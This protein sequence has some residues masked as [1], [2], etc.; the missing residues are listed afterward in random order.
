MR[1]PGTAC[2]AKASEAFQ[3]EEV[4]IA[5]GLEDATDSGSRHNRGAR[6]STETCIPT[7]NGKE[8]LGL[9]TFMLPLTQLEKRCSIRRPWVEAHTDSLLAWSR[10]VGHTLASSGCPD[11]ATRGNSLLACFVDG[12][13]SQPALFL[14]T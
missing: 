2:A 14:E 3:L 4:V 1:L 13:E 8:S 6:S 11:Q 12:F 10:Q 5:M 7:V 9:F